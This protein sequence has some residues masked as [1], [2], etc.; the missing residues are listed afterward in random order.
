MNIHS[1]C[2]KLW[3]NANVKLSGSWSHCA[4]RSRNNLTFPGKL[5]KMKILQFRLG[6]FFKLGLE[7]K[8]MVWMSPNDIL[9][10][11]VHMFLSNVPCDI[12]YKTNVHISPHFE[13]LILNNNTRCIFFI[14]L[15][16]FYKNFAAL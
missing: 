10:F 7:R 2:D 4:T 9:S 15:L 12:T 6:I 1:P 3:L 16:C 5:P 11:V 14:F 13:I 8:L